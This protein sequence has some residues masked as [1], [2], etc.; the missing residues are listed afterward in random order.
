MWKELDGV[1]FTVDFSRRRSLMIWSI[2]CG[3]EMRVVP[4][5]FPLIFTCKKY[6]KLP[7]T[8][9]SNFVSRICCMIASIYLLS[10]PEIMVSSV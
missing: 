2:K 3:C 5:S 10:G 4:S 6:C 9:R 1:D 8:V 7:K